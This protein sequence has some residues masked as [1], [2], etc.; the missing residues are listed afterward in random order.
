MLRKQPVVAVRWGPRISL[1]ED[2]G[3]V[4]LFVEHGDLTFHIALS[5]EDAD[6]L[7]KQ[8][9]LWAGVDGELCEHLDADRP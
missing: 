6:K 5:A 9:I 8:L 3:T 2:C 7:G 4:D 1:A